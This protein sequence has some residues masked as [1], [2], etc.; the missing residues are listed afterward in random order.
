ARILSDNHWTTDVALGAAVGVASGYLL[1][2]LLHY[3]A[4]GVATT[5]FPR[6]KGLVGRAP[7][8][9]VFA[10]SYVSGGAG[11][12]TTGVFLG[13]APQEKP[14]SSDV[15]TASRGKSCLLRVGFEFAHAQRVHTA[16]AIRD[17]EPSDAE[18]EV[19][20]DHHLEP[21]VAQSGEHDRCREENGPRG[22]G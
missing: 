8:V 1:P 17:E 7:F 18:Q 3:G 16:D 12:V 21:G 14:I 5:L 11:A 10:P 6:G 19:D 4:D 2:S 22:D 15:V 9:L 20:A 13:T